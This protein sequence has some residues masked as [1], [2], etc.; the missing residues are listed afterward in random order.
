MA[1]FHFIRPLWLLSLIPLL[2]I[3][4]QL[5]RVSWA[6][7]G[8]QGII[9]KHLVQHLLE[10]QQSRQRAPLALIGFVWLV[11]TIALAGPTWQRIPQ[12]IFEAQAG[13]VILLDM[14]MSMR[15]TD[16]TPDRLT[17]ARF[18]AMELV[19]QITEGDI[20]LVAYA[21]DAFVI[22]PLT[23][24][25]NN[26]VT[27]VPSLTPDIMPV[28]GSDPILGLSK[29]T[30]LLQ[31]AGYAEGDIIW[32]TDGV[33]YQDME[34]LNVFAQETQY[35]LLT[36]GIGSAGGAPIKLA[37]GDLMRDAYGAIVI[38]KLDARLLQSISHKTNGVYI[39]MTPDDSD[40]ALLIQLLSQVDSIKENNDEN[41]QQLGDQWHEAGPWLVLLILPLAAYAFRRGVIYSL[42]PFVFVLTGL[43]PKPVQAAIWDN[44]WKTADQQGQEAFKNED[45]ASAEQ[46]FQD[47]RWQAASQLKQGNY[48]GAIETLSEFNDAESLYNK[49]NA[50]A[51]MGKLD[52]AIK[53]YEQ[54]LKQQPDFE[55]AKRNK[56]L[57]EQLKQQQEQQNQ[58]SDQNQDGEKQDG[59]QQD[60]QGENQDQQNGDQSNEQ[61]NENKESGE[62]GQ[63]SADQQEQQNGEQ[64]EEDSAQTAEEKAQQAAEEKAEQEAKEQ[65]EQQEGEQ[66]EGDETQQPQ[67]A[68]LTDEERQNQEQQ[69]VIQKLLNKVEDDPAFLLRRK[70]AIEA[71]ERQR[72]QQ[73]KGVNKTW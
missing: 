13:K 11:L 57:A 46:H 49:G 16:I 2:F 12:P 42:L 3:L 25:S 61:N 9:P 17:R 71:N 67:T 31:D 70:M 4:W 19:G 51:N 1:D 72:T 62:E 36:L 8:W 33:D 28:A 40:I 64:S 58:D 26:L 27:L 52:E 23:P 59:E 45:Y 54:A 15:A 48:E 30:E 5:Q 55:N 6:R 32:I 56:A 29:A 68:E 21:G 66:Q 39:D 69:Q 14:S 60:Q 50:L 24:D 20:G 10:G 43:F 22:S 41:D 18:K 37:N 53:S 38:P 63:Q 35:R 44:L 47:K 65:A 7:S 34:D 73:P